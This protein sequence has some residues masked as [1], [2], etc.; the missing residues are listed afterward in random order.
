MLYVVIGALL[1]IFVLA[2]VQTVGFA[3][4]TQEVK[5]SKKTRRIYSAV[6]ALLISPLFGLVTDFPWFVPVI[7]GLW[8]FLAI[9]FIPKKATYLHVSLYTLGMFAVAG[10]AFYVIGIFY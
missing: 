8:L 10:L 3:K 2:I 5:P 1:L 6:M 4:Q 9:I 7:M